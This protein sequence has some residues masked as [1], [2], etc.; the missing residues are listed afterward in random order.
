[1]SPAE[2]RVRYPEF[3]DTNDV[4]LQRWLT[5]AESQT[6]LE[7]WAEHRDK[8]ICLLAAHYLALSPKGRNARLEGSTQTVYGIARADLEKLVQCCASRCP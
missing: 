6:P 7:V 1:M 2:F 5:E 8:G 3:A 4:Q